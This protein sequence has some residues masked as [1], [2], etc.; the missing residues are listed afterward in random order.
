[1]KKF[2]LIFLTLVLGLSVVFAENFTVEQYDL[3]IA[4]SID[5]VYT[6][7]EHIVLNY[8]TPS[9]GF[10]RSI[11]YRYESG[12]EAKVTNIKV[13][14][15]F[16]K[17]YAGSNIDLKIGDAD[18]LVK[19]M[20][21]YNISYIF[22]LG[23]DGYP[24]YDE[25]YYNLV[26][27]GW[28]TDVKNISYS[29][30]FPKAITADRIWLTSGAFGSTN[31]SKEY[32]LNNNN[33][34]IQGKVSKLADNEALTLR[35]E[36]DPGFF[37]NAWVKKDFTY[38]GAIAIIL[39]GIA[40]IF[41]FIMFYKKYGV[42]KPLTVVVNFEAPNGLSPL[43]CGYVIDSSADDK[44][45]ASMIFYW[46]DKRYLTIEEVDKKKDSF[47]FHKIKELPETASKAEKE[48]F[49]AL[50]S[51]GDES[52]TT[53]LAKSGFATKINEKVKPEV[54]NYFVKEKA[55]IDPKS[56]S[57]KGLMWIF[58]L[59]FTIIYSFGT[60][61]YDLDFMII[62]LIGSLIFLAFSF[63]FSSLMKKYSYVKKSARIGILIGY[64]IVSIL[65]L[66]AIIFIS[67][68]GNTSLLLTFISFVFFVI[69]AILASF[70]GNV[71]EKLSDYGQHTIE[72][73]LGFKEFIDKVEVDK[74]K[75]LIDQDPEY[76]YHI[77]S[78]AI[79]FG[80][81]DKWAKKFNGIFIEPASW[82]TSSSYTAGD[83]FFYTAMYRRWNNAYRTQI[84]PAS[85]QT[86]SGKG[87][88]STFSGSSGFSGG[89][90]G[91]GGG[92]S[93]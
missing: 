75:L 34:V 2:I 12:K 43:E 63:L 11:P 65:I 54:K 76:F 72:N 71:M 9:H 93:W 15:N 26:G 46:A 70:G 13:D 5:R 48:L 78:Y 53:D 37:E 55:L 80:L 58:A 29:I 22:N 10:Y 38:L 20:K 49:N 7:N 45:V 25:F 16:D 57:K 31:Q 84:F 35:V 8:T 50:F 32:Q 1:M 85:Y 77:L 30:T 92:R 47:I 73:V 79:C 44:D 66:G 17:E 62:V 6:V 40:F 39:S 88:A 23:D 51:K 64:I 24:D 83:Y 74:L 91:G 87:G 3:D 56:L 27:D 52:S 81:E 28:A 60:C 61:I 59:L 18:K 4:V 90:F 33:T 86:G 69:V 41:L 19:G 89:G 67:A 21:E 14:E 42:D 68:L 36:M 82:Y